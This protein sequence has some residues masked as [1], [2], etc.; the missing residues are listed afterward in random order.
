[1]FNS[2]NGDSNSGGLSVLLQWSL[3][4]V[5]HYSTMAR[6][7][8]SIDSHFSTYAEMKSLQAQ[9]KTLRIMRAIDRESAKDQTIAELPAQLTLF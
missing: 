1:M 6:E 7:T 3:A 4:R 5:E 2:Q 9:H 8:R